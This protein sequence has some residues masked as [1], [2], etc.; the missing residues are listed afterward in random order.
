MDQS[1]YYP[2][3]RA[4]RFAPLKKLIEEQKQHLSDRAKKTPS[5]EIDEAFD[6]VEDFEQYAML[7]GAFPG[8]I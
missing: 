2:V 7:T 1:S 3:F 6:W 5:G 4:K 8:D